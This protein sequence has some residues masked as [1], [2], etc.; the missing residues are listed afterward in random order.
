[1]QESSRLDYEWKE[2]KQVSF[3]LL[4]EDRHVRIQMLRYLENSDMRNSRLSRLAMECVC[5]CVCVFA[6]GS[7]QGVN[8]QN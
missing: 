4:L 1:M 6:R 3:T 7:F 8:W 2:V 5:V